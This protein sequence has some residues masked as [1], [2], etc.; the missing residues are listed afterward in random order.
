MLHVGVIGPSQW[1][2]WTND[3]EPISEA[4][5]RVY[6]LW[7]G[8]KTEQEREKWLAQATK[9]KAKSSPIAVPAPQ[10]KKRAAGGKR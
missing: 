9:R 4:M 3:T 8:L 2:K 7:K 5:L 1:S 10:E 6:L